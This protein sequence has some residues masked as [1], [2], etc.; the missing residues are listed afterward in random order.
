MMIDKKNTPLKQH[1]TTIITAA[2][3]IY[4]LTGSFGVMH[5]R[6]DKTVT[7]DLSY[8]ILS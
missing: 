8:H 7:T 4:M 1:T 2:I 5:K 6:T 3:I